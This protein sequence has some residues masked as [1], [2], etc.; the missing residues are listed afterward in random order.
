MNRA[1]NMA[2]NEPSLGCCGRC[3]LRGSTRLTSP[4][5]SCSTMRWPLW[6]RVSIPCLKTFLSRCRNLEHRGACIDSCSFLWS[7]T[8]KCFAD[9][10]HDITCLQVDDCARYA[11]RQVT[12]SLER[13]TLRLWELEKV[14]SIASSVCVQAFPLQLAP[15]W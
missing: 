5:L 1:L 14:T 7:R 2:G 9:P 11:G 6:E 12:F 10:A 3:G 15:R 8:H 4:T 13:A